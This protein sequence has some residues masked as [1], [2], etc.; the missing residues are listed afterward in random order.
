M[1]SWRRLGLLAA[2]LAAVLTVVVVGTTPS[3]QAQVDQDETVGWASTGKITSIDTAA[4]MVEI[5]EEDGTSTVFTCDAKTTIMRGDKQVGIGDL[6][7]GMQV[8]VNGDMRSGN[9]VATY[10]EVVDQ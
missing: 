10:L 7:K 1:G 6:E 5:E 3:A 8:V 2:C 4:K 9:R